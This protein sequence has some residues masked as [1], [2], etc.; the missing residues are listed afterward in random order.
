MTALPPGAGEALSLVLRSAGCA[1]Q[2]HS[3]FPRKAKQGTSSRPGAEGGTGVSLLRPA[4]PPGA[5]EAFQ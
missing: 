4:V 2:L 3:R 1:L 5:S